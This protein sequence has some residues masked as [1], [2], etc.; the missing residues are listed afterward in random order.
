MKHCGLNSRK[1]RPER[2]QALLKEL[3]QD[4]SEL[5]LKP[6]F[7]R[8][9]PRSGQCD[10]TTDLKKIVMEFPDIL[11]GESVGRKKAQRSQNVDAMSS[12]R[13]RDA[14]NIFSRK[15]AQE[16]Q[17]VGT[18]RNGTKLSPFQSKNVHTEAT[19]KTKQDSEK[20]QL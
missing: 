19:K 14:E 4:Y 8:F 3:T 2:G 20:R 16:A 13:S 12:S 7:S 17:K 15:K 5:E 11:A 18:D 1:N 6:V 9:G 10:L